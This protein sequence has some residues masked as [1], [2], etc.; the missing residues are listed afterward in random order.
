MCTRFLPMFVLLS[1]F[2]GEWE[3]QMPGESLKQLEHPHYP[4]QNSGSK[5][6]VQ[7]SS[8][9]FNYLIQSSDFVHQEGIR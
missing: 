5:E 3:G 8:K 4:N 2:L 1:T 7:N 9:I 6:I